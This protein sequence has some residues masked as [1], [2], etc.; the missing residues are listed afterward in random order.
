[1]LRTPYG[2]HIIQLEEM[3]GANQR[4]LEQV[5]EKIRVFLQARKRQEAYLEFLKEVKSKARILINERLWTE[6]EKK[7]EKTR[8]EKK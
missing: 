5:K 1:V 3:R 8:E 7:G 6:E 2:Y 4:P